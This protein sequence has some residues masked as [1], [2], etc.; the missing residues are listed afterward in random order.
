MRWVFGI[1]GVLV[2]LVAVVLIV[3]TL[4]PKAHVAS[5]SARY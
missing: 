2:V 3:G 4:L 1:A 5:M